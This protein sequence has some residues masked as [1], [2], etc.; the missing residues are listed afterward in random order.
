[1]LYQCSHLPD[2]V[3]FLINVTIVLLQHICLTIKQYKET[4]NL[5]DRL[6]FIKLH[7]HQM[8]LLCTLYTGN[9]CEMYHVREA[10]YYQNYP[11]SYPLIIQNTPIISQY[12]ASSFYGRL[13]WGFLTF[14]P[15][16]LDLNAKIPITPN[17]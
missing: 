7:I 13:I 1:M 10:T 8:L 9:S 3:L 6:L 14:L 11:T 5:I 17:N 2:S 12:R 15:C 4:D 16:E